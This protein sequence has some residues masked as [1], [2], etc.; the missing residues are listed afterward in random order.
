MA[1]CKESNGDTWEIY[2]QGNQWRW[3]RSA[4]NGE[5]VGASTESYVNK[6]DCLANAKRHGMTCNP[7]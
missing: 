4:S 6:S 3:R 5:V 2:Q 7:T 1:S